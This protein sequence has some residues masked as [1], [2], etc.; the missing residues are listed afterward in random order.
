MKKYFKIRQV[1][2]ILKSIAK[3]FAVALPPYFIIKG[4]K[5]CVEL[6]AV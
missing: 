5:K 4:E 1:I 2:E 3:L 6:Q